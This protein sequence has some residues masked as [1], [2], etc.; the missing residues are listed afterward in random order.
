MGKFG[1]GSATKLKP[2]GNLIGSSLVWTAYIKSQILWVQKTGNRQIPKRV[3]PFH[4]APK[5]YDIDS[6]YFKLLQHQITK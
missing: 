2:F 6:A 3:L 4:R 5:R 1:V